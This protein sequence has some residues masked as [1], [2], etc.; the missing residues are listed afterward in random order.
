MWNF[1]ELFIF[2]STTENSRLWPE[3]WD[4][5]WEDHDFVMKNLFKCKPFFLR[6]SYIIYTLNC[7]RALNKPIHSAKLQLRHLWVCF[8]KFPNIGL[9]LN[10]VS[11]DLQNAVL[12]EEKKPSRTIS[13]LSIKIWWFHSFCYTNFIPKHVQ[14]KMFSLEKRKE[15]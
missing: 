3:S 8:F 1:S 9:V 13:K 6:R 12:I 7:V 11:L 5:T 2:L 4:L 15:L 14:R 10:A